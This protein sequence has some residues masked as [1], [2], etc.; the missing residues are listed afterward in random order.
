MRFQGRCW[1]ARHPRMCGDS[2]NIS[3][4]ATPERKMPN[5]ETILDIWALAGKIKKSSMCQYLR[6]YVSILF[7]PFLLIFVFLANLC[8]FVHRLIWHGLTGNRIE[9][10]PLVMRYWS[11]YGVLIQPDIIKPLS[12]VAL[13]P[14][15]CEVGYQSITH[16][17][18]SIYIYILD[19]KVRS[20][21]NVTSADPSDVSLKDVS[22]TPFGNKHIFWI[23]IISK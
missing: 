4:P 10:S 20:F 15:A 1:V 9:T 13:W 18:V 22:K 2:Q 19:I 23:L 7:I 16:S 3:Q 11:V 21:C 8:V 14:P 17:S 6:M 12:A 5:Q